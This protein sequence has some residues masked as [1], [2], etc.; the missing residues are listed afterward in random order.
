MFPRSNLCIV[1]DEQKTKKKKSYFFIGIWSNS[2]CVCYFS[3]F[4]INSKVDVRFAV[5][6]MVVSMQKYSNTIFSIFFLH[7]T[8]SGAFFFSFYSLFHKILLLHILA[9]LGRWNFNTHIFGFSQS[10]T[11][12]YKLLEEQNDIISWLK[13]ICPSPHVSTLIYESYA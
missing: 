6:I 2:L 12:Y 5:S 3:L 11:K 8:T 1:V 13:I 7:V 4:I 9:K 10:W